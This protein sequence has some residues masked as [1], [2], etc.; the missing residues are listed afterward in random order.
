MSKAFI[1]ILENFS[2]QLKV[3]SSKKTYFE[4]LTAA[5]VND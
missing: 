3:N 2:K 4:N 1:L 5:I